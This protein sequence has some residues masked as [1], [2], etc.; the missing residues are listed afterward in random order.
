ME[1]KGEGISIAEYLASYLLDENW[2]HEHPS[3]SIG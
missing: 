2:F 3:C 1:I